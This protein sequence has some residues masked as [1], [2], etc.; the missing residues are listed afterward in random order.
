MLYD[1]QLMDWYYHWYYTV[2]GTL[3]KDLFMAFSLANFFQNFRISN[4]IG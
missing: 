1:K 3:R 4:N 2:V